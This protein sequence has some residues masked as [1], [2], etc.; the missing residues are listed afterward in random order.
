MFFDNKNAGGSL[1]PQ[2]TP[3]QA[4]PAASANSLFSSNV[5]NPSAPGRLAEQKDGFLPLPGQQQKEENRAGVTSNSLNRAFRERF[6]N[7]ANYRFLC[8]TLLQTPNPEPDYLLCLVV[9]D[10]TQP[11]AKRLSLCAVDVQEVE[12]Q[13]QAR[14]PERASGRS[15][16]NRWQIEVHAS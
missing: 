12:R 14:G 16:V 6:P 15:P 4:F 11:G 2:P 13:C 10:W 7:E 1:F 3:F 9:D 5:G 8:Q